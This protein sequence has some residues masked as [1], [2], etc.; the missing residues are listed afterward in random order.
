MAL[1]LMPG[2]MVSLTDAS[3]NQL[4]MVFNDKNF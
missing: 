4:S 3:V 1:G 2:P